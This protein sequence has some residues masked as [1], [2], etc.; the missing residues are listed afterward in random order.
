MIPT[1]RPGDLLAVRLPGPGEPRAGQLVVATTDRSDLVK[2][3][4]AVPGERVRGRLLD[5]DEFWLEGDNAAGSTDSRTTGP[6][7]RDDI[8]GVVRARYWP[9]SRI[10]RL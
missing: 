8:I 7:A 1:L 3:V 2:R 5:R 4:V 6:V 9:L 10:C